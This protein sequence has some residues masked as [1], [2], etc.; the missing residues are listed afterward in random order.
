MTAPAHSWHHYR[1]AGLAIRSLLALPEWDLFAGGVAERSDVDIRLDPESHECVEDAEPT[2]DGEA[3]QFSIAE[4]GT[5]RIA[6]GRRIDIR[7][8]RRAHENEL[9]LFT[10]GSAW[11]A[12]GYQRGLAM[13]HGSAVAIAGRALL[14]CGAQEQGKSTM[15]AAMVARGHRLLVDDLSRVDPP[16]IE[17]PALLHPSTPRLKLWHDAIDHFGMRHIVVA[18]DH[19]RAEKYHLAV[20]GP[21][22][23]Q[24]LPL[25]AIVVLEWGEELQLE[26]LHGAR[27]VGAV[28]AACTYRPQMLAA[29]GI[30]AQ[31]SA[32]LARIVAASPTYRLTRPR[33]LGR[34]DA[35]CELLTT[36]AGPAAAI[37][38]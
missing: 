4:V 15:A 28:I 26:P 38:G 22:A 29:M 3:L 23:L 8:A 33:D 25:A 35:A 13:V 18:R 27:A 30:E 24:P 11:G 12:L 32:Q 6:E 37:P 7:P 20:P 5:W 14:F 16:A 19:F 36:L 17:G 21:A 9:R 34:I 1:Q 2:W 31:Q 10:L